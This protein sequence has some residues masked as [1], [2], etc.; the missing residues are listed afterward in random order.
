MTFQT[1]SWHL[2]SLSNNRKA[3]RKFP[4]LK[5]YVN[6]SVGN[7][8]KGKEG[9]NSLETV[10]VLQMRADNGLVNGSSNRNIKCKQNERH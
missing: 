3:L 4:F 7:G 9:E 8:L 1:M 5:D 6:R 10:V 2:D